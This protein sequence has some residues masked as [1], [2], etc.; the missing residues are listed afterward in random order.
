MIRKG[1]IPIDEIIFL[2]YTIEFVI[3]EISLFSSSI[4]IRVLLIGTRVS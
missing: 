1:L 3:D 2:A 4:G